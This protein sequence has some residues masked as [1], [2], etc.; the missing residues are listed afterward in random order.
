MAA[1]LLSM[2]QEQIGKLC[3]M[4]LGALKASTQGPV[5]IFPTRLNGQSALGLEGRWL[6]DPFLSN[7][8]FWFWFL[9]RC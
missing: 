3:Q 8:L 1:P 4:A 2:Y 5:R 7:D 6:D 9:F